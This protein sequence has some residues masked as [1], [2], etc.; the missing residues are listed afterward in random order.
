MSPEA[1]SLSR[2]RQAGRRG[3]QRRGSG[4]IETLIALEVMTLAMIGILQLFSLSIL[5]NG[6]AAARTVMMFKAQ[7]V[8]ENMRIAM[9][10][11][12]VARPGGFA[13]PPQQIGVADGIN[14]CTSGGTVF[15]G[16]GTVAM[17][18][19]AGTYEL[20]YSTL[21]AYTSA[22]SGASLPNFWGPQGAGVVDVVNGPFRVTITVEGTASPWTVT[23]TCYP[24]ITS[25]TNS[26]FLG[27]AAALTGK[28]IDYVAQLR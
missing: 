1:G 17:T 6:V 16:G 22:V 9:A 27:G 11:G 23:V 15:S 8:V 14:K 26:T 24:E 13:V 28:R 12:A 20:P 19:N 5:V 21:P 18:P 3:R 10:T 4:L 2:S 7:Q 25:A